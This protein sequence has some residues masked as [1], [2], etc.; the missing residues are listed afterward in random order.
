MC[1]SNKSF[2][3]VNTNSQLQ[4]HSICADPC[5]VSQH[6]EWKTYQGSTNLSNHTLSWTS[7]PSTH[8]FGKYFLNS[9][10][11]SHLY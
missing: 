7:F 8:I 6:I 4:L 10:L 5:P 2:Y 1:Q 3:Y 9:L 11:Y